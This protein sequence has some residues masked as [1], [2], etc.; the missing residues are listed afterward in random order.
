MNDLATL[1]VSPEV[2]TRLQAYAARANDALAPNTVRAL[3][4]DIRIYMTWCQTHGRQPLPATPATVAAFV[5]AMSI[6]RKPYT[7]RR[8]VASISTLHRAASLP[9]PTSDLVVSLALKTAGKAKGLRQKQAKGLTWDRL[10]PVIAALPDDLRGLRDAALLCTA[11]DSLCRVA[12]L[13]GLVVSDLNR[14]DD[15]DGTVL[16]RS[17]KT[18]QQGEGMTRYLAPSTITRLQTWFNAAGIDSGPMFRPI[19][20][21]IR[22]QPGRFSTRGITRVLQRRL[23]EAG[24]PAEGFSGHS[25]RVGAA[26]DLVEANASLLAVMNAGGWKSAAMPKRYTEEQAARKGAMARLAKT[27]RR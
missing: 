14:H 18:D 16:V 17:S 8:Y 20:G 27:Q 6:E 22:V 24:L 3:V 13:S 7:V 26:Q 1:P 12:E 4:S 9:N 11:Y 23:Q 21:H 5:D 25:T 19:L 15:G 10:E 2:R